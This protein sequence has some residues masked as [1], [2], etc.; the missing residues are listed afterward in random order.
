MPCVV[1][2]EVPHVV[3]R[4][5]AVLV[6]TIAP[7]N[8]SV[9]SVVEDA[10]VPASAHRCD[11]LSTLVIVDADVVA[12]VSRSTGVT[13]ALVAVDADDAPFLVG[14]VSL[15]HGQLG[16]P[17]QQPLL[18]TAR[19]GLHELGRCR[20]HVIISRGD[21]AIQVAAAR[22]EQCCAEDEHRP[23]VKILHECSLPGSWVEGLN[24]H[25]IKK[26]PCQYD[27]AML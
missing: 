13:V 22:D 7:V 15:R 16:C 3:G 14:D 17:I 11:E 21:V 20:G 4:V 5:L 19:D 8:E 1:V 12:V 24:K 27:S 26:A 18:G 6:E 23:V 2:R 10:D 25:A 9:A